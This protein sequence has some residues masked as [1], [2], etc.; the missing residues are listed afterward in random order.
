MAIDSKRLD[1]IFNDAVAIESLT[2]RAAHV[3]RACG[4][5]AALRAR[6]MA[7]LTAHDAARSFLPLDDADRTQEAVVPIREGP[8][9]TIGRSKILQQIG[10]GG[11]GAVFMA[12][13]KH[14]I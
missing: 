10:E 14:P 4:N 1:G 6:V 8:G 11:F 2:E 3:D 12:E 5:D 7:L 13:Q 9:S